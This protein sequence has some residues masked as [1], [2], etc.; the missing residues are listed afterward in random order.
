MTFQIES[1]YRSNRRALTW[2]IFFALLWTMRDFFSL[3]FLTFVF[4][5]IGA[6]II[7][8]AQNRLHLPRRLAIVS[9]FL[10][11]TAGIVSFAS[12]VLP[13]VGREAITLLGKLDE[14][15]G[16]LIDLKNQL[17]IR[18]PALDNALMSA[19]QGSVEEEEGKKSGSMLIPGVPGG[20]RATTE[21]LRNVYFSISAK[22]KPVAAADNPTTI[23]MDAVAYAVAQDAIDDEK[24]IK[25][26]ISQKGAVIREMAPGVLG[27]MGRSTLTML[28]ALLFSFL[29]TMDTTRLLKEID[30][31]K[32]SRLQ[33]FYE[34]TAQPIVR[35]G[36]VLGRA[37]Q[38][39]A[40]IAVCNT[41]LTLTGLL[42][43]KVP[44]LAVLSLIVF[45]CGFIPVLGVFISTT[46]IVL[47]ALN[48]GGFSTALWV[49]ALVVLVHLVEAYLLNPLIY[50]H[51]LKLNPV[52]VLIILF[53]GHHAFGVWGMLLG[54]P[55]VYYLIH[56]VFGVPLWKG[57]TPPGEAAASNK[58]A[59]AE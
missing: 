35:F 14:M 25:K 10:F 1:F 8:F 58:G 19:I 17:A 15:E 3:I 53:V 33:D 22:K 13:Q 54:V 20:E 45:L 37:M 36:T 48:T 29:I 28:F 59:A 6:P 46:P 40:V 55:V 32:F 27:A 12:F 16:R 30:R 34:Q 9:V 44:S 11:F 39:Q 5:F 38:A 7:A 23:T 31:L 56:D 18:N 24:I 43:L 49:L 57:G 4:A 47:V 26:F 52:L 41:V 21:T 42:I 2:I 51:H 50:G